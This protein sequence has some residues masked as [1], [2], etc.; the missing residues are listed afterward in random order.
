MTRLIALYP[1]DWR[2]RYEVEFL[3]LLAERPPDPAGRLDI[4]LGAIDARLHPQVPGSHAAPEPPTSPRRWAI[5][6]GWLTLVGGL[7]WVA[8]LIVATNG[9]IVVDGWGTYRERAAAAP[10]FFVALILLGTGIVAVALDLPAG[11]RL[12]RAGA[13]VACLSGLLWAFAPWLLVAGLI[14]GVGITA[15]ALSAWEA[16]RWSGIDAALLVGGQII[17]WTLPAGVAFGLVAPGALGVDGIVLPLSVMLSA[18][19]AVGHALI[20][21]TPSAVT[22]RSGNGPT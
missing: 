16:G 1:R 10:L 19:I 5:R 9:P 17:G 11:A 12:G 8:T 20:R 22:T 21:G 15:V 18:W 2:E 6:V 4:L 3:A 13:Y 14:A 7:L